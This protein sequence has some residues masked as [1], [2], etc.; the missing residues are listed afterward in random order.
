MHRSLRPL[1]FAV[2][3]L[4]MA[5]TLGPLAPFASAVEKTPT[6]T[7]EARARNAEMKRRVDAWLAKGEDVRMPVH[8]VYLSCADQEPFK[9]YRERINRVLT[10]A[11][12]WMAAQTDAAGFGRVTM[13]LERDDDKMVKLHMGK[14]PFDVGTRER[15]NIRET[16]KAC[17]D[18]A[19]KLLAE[20]GVDYDRSFVLVLT[21]IPDDHGAAPFFGNIIQNK[22][23]CYAVDTPWLDTNYTT[24]D[25]P[26]VWK[27]KPIGPANSALVGGIVHELGH[28][29][30]LPHSDEPP[31]EKSFGESLMASGNYTWRRELRGKG[32]GSY[33]LDTDAMFLIARPP[34]TGRVRDFDKQP[35]TKFEELR[36][37]L[38]D[39]G[40]V[41]V[42]G[43][44][45]TDIPAH[46]VKVYD[47]PPGKNDYNAVAHAA[48]PDEKTGEFTITF[49]PHRAPGEHALRLYACHVNGRWTRV[50]T[51][52]TVTNDGVAL[53]K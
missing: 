31:A 3:C 11:Q 9:G 28:G 37:K 15:G 36:F 33:L 13:H 23:Y 1:I 26:K 52:M 53:P 25:G 20:V 49:K 38:L 21:T 40:R 42:T 29:L 46:A 19:K 16:H 34:F 27:N 24:T 14:L 47:D 8:V 50:S 18:A 32:K 12:E 39:D 48:L 7:P 6:W 10:E 45:E 41:E 35:K 51:K 2:V 22:G 17:R 5:A 30:G 43:R 44:V 4:T